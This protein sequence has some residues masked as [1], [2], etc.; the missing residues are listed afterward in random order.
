MLKKIVEVSAL[1]GQLFS[2]TEILIFAVL[3]SI[4]EMLLQVYTIIICTA[5][6]I[7]S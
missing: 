3:P 4:L 5:V 7:V 2:I 1:H 6:G